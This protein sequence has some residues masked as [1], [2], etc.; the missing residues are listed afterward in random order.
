MKNTEGL[1]A[2]S[3]ILETNFCPEKITVQPFPLRKFPKKHEVNSLRNGKTT[4]N[5]LSFVVRIN[6]RTSGI[7]MQI[8]EGLLYQESFFYPYFRSFLKFFLRKQNEE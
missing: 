4:D 2:K 5:L 7:V 1:I 8:Y 6:V 3:G